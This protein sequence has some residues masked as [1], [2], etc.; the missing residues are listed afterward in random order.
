MAPQDNQTLTDFIV[1]NVPHPDNNSTIYDE[2]PTTS[3]PAGRATDILIS[4]QNQIS[5]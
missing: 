4:I 5:M 3:L 1:F 2:P